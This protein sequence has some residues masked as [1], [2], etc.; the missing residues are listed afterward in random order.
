FG[1]PYRDK[2]YTVITLPAAIVAKLVAADPTV[3]GALATASDGSLQAGTRV[4][5]IASTVNDPGHYGPGQ[6][7]VIVSMQAGPAPKQNGPTL[8]YTFSGFNT[9]LP[10][11]KNFAPPSGAAATQ[12][13]ITGSNFAYLS[14][15]EIGR[16]H[17]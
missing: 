12:V 8:T 17:V 4:V 2:G 3:A 10:V 1:Q 16:A 9:L 7:A 14:K 6:G 11:A 5:N 13:T 15:G